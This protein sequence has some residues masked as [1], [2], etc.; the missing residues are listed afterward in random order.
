VTGAATFPILRWGAL[1]WLAVM[2]PAYWYF[3]GPANFLLLCDIAI[4]LTTVGLWKGS[5]LLL[6]MQAVSSLLL[7]LIW[8]LDVV[9]RLVTGRHWIGGTEY[10]WDAR[11]PLWLRLLSL[12]HVLLPPVLLWGLHRVGY[13]RRAPWVQS[14]I[15]AAAM[16][17]GRLTA[18]AKNS[19]YAFADPFFHRQWGPAPVHVAFMWLVML[20]VV[21]LPVHLLLRRLFAPPG[22]L[23][24]RGAA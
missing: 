12:F 8:D 3:Y 21:Y 24:S 7:D 13:D 18:P 4:I 6:S 20:V 22:A 2:L 5:A 23:R 19:N 15:A 17:A 1:L 9:A 14:A 16:A 10:M 11:W